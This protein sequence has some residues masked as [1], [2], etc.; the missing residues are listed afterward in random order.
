M[1]ASLVFLLLLAVLASSLASPTDTENHLVRQRRQ[2]NFLGNTRLLV[3][4]L[5]ENLRKSAKDA[6]DAIRTFRVGVSDQVKELRD[7]VS[8]NLQKL[9][10]RVT[11]AIQSITDRFSNSSTAVRDCVNAHKG[12]TE[13]LFNETLKSTLT[14]ADGRVKEIGDQ[15]DDLNDVATNASEFANTAME[16]MKACMEQNQDSQNILTT[17][18]CLGRVAIQTEL[19]AGSFLAQST[20]AISRI[21][22]ALATLPLALEACAGTQLMVTGVATTKIIVEIGSCSAASVFSTFTGSSS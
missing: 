3:E 20:L 1:R 13:T 11:Q 4:Q 15:L 14:C 10:D 18:S 21:N 12:E 7:R 5:I 6:V 16:Q 19:K 9:R 17:G 2:I 8:A 22:F